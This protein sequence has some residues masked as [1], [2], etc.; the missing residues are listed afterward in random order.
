MDMAYLNRPM[1]TKKLSLKN[2]L[3]L[4]AMH[5]VEGGSDGEM[6]SATLDYYEEKTRGGYLGLV[7]TQHLYMTKQGKASAGQLSIADDSTIEGMKELVGVIHG[8]GSKVV[9]QINHAG[10]AASA[11]VTGLEVV[12]AS[13]IGNPR[14]GEAPRELTKEE[15]GSI[16]RGFAEAARRVKE[17][18]F[19]GVEIHGAHGY[20]LSQFYSPLTNKRTDEYGGPVLNRIRI[21]LEIIKAV[22]EAVGEEF[23]VLLRLGASD[24]MDQG[25]TIED[26][27]IACPEF[28]KAGVDLLDISGGFAGYRK[29]GSKE[30]G[31]FAELTEAIKEVVSIPVILTGGITDYTVAEALLE[32]G[33]ADLIGVGRAMLADSSWAKHAMLALDSE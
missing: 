4:P 1:E 28:E 2:R 12:G 26:S 17:A 22:R 21:H 9:A 8:N 16:V 15:I 5:F 24:Y 32:K 13:S 30:Q 6:N 3:V 31:Y 33:K 29:P 14:K 19:D 18:E 23:P 20:L 27:V 25:A 11:E 10:S 7:V